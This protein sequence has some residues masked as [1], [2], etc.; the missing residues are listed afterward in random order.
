MQILVNHFGWEVIV[1]AG[2]PSV[3]HISEERKDGLRVYR[4]PILW[5]VSNTPIHPLWPQ[6]IR[7]IISTEKPDLINAHAPVPF[8]SDVAAMMAGRIPFV[9]TYHAS[10]MRKKVFI[11][12]VIVRVY[13]RFV[14]PRM[15]NNPQAIICSS[16]FVR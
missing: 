1:A 16:G 12:D 10:T 11:P 3:K 6:W 2:S 7:K 15:L 4:L 9:L 8:I 13:E 14:L 5:T